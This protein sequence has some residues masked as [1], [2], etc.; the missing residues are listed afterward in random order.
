[1]LDLGAVYDIADVYLNGVHLGILWKPPFRVD[2]TKAARKGTNK[3]VVEITNSWQNRLAGDGRLPKAERVTRSNM[4]YSRFVYSD[5]KVEWKDQI[6]SDSGLLGPVRIRT[7]K[8][9]KIT[10]DH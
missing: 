3:L 10:F 6:L 7:A 9:V 8:T 2:I 1:M 4:I 5:T